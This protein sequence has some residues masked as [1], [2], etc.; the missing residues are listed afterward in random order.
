MRRKLSILLFLFLILRAAGEQKTLEQLKAEAEH[1]GD[2]Q[3]KILAEV[4]ER[5]VPVA[6][7]QFT[8]G[9]SI[10][11][12]ATIDEI[13]QY[14]TRAHDLA[15]QTRKKMK[16]TEIHLRRCRYALENLRRTL[17]AEDRPA[18]EAVE[19]KLEQFGEEVLEAMFAGP[20]KA[21]Q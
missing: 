12:H 2:N 18:V 10:K 4:A 8:D 16:D 1:P 19:K 13:L 21:Q 3:P 5:L 7:K 9:E 15:I 17:A 20:K 6:D 14:S 11:G